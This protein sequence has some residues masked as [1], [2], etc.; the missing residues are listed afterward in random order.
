MLA[1]YLRPEMEKIWSEENFFSLCLK[2]EIL[3]AEAMC[4]KGIVPA[5]A[6]ADIKAKARFS[7][8]RIAEI[9]KT[10]HHQFISFLSCVTENIGDSGRYL[11]LGLTSSDVLDTAFALQL[12]Q[13]ADIVLDDTK[14]LCDTLK[15]MALQYKNTPIIGRTH[16]MHAEPTT[17]GLVLLGFYQ[18]WQRNLS[19][20]KAAREEISVTA[21]S[22][23]V[24]NFANVDLDVEEYVASHLDLR[25]EPVSTQVIPRDRF[26]AFFVVSAL[27]ASSM[28]RLATEIRHL[29][30]TELAEAKESF[31]KGQK[32]SSAMPHKSNPILS[33][34]L[35][36]LARVIRAAVI[37]AMENVVLWHERDMSHSSAE[38]FIAPDT[39]ATL[40]FALVR[41][42]SILCGLEVN[43]D[44]MLA[45]INLQNGL[46][47]SQRV[48][49]V[50]VDKG[51]LRDIAYRYVQA[52]AMRVWHGECSFRTALEETRQI[53][54]VLT[55]AD[56]DALFDLKYYMKNIDNIFKRALGL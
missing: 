20:L 3:V 30:R 36:G 22:G 50:L 41:L 29:Q 31:A 55:P 26:A 6:L 14:Q 17:F 35:C 28:E 19:R 37:P 54:E 7:T 13:S 44:K 40:D 43:T 33:E 2:V 46:V 11:H 8:D 18:E 48:L 38:R 49:L 56:F 42:N 34:N 9:E 16:G 1:R 21:I 25:A 52:A 47:F 53:A 24:G 23:A 27:L 10:T 39:T 45:D 5:N 4:E 32:G 12:R 51:M 15:N